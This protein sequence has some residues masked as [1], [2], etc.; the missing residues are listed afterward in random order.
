M[1]GVVTAARVQA[2]WSIRLR[3]GDGNAE[4]DGG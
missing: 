3:V 2:A 4:V 1:Q